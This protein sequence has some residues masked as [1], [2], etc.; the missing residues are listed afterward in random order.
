MK[1]KKT[2]KTSVSDSTS[3]RRG[4]LWA[5]EADEGASKRH[6]WEKV[7]RSPHPT[8]HLKDHSGL[9]QQ[10]GPHVGPNDVVPFIKA[11]LNVLPKTA[12][13][14]IASGFSISNGLHRTNR[15]NAK[16]GKLS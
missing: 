2:T 9:L 15:R 3:K 14:V 6:S 12:A 4:A 10:V 16:P 5:Q 1:E 8:T 7:Q 11:N 13:V